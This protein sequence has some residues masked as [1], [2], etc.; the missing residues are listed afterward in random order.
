MVLGCLWQKM[1]ISN[2]SDTKHDASSTQSILGLLETVERA[3]QQQ[4][5]P[6][7][8][9]WLLL[10]SSLMDDLMAAF[11]GNY[12]IITQL[13]R[14]LEGGLAF[15]QL[16]DETIDECDAI[17]NIREEILCGR[18]QAAAAESDS[19]A[20]LDYGIDY[21]ERYFS[22]ITFCAYLHDDLYRGGMRFGAW[23]AEHQEIW[24]LLQSIRGQK[25][26]LK[27]FRPISHLQPCSGEVCANSNQAPSLL[28][29]A[30]LVKGRSG[31][32][33]SSQTILKMDHYW[34][35]SNATDSNQTVIRGA[36]NFRHLPGDYPIYATA[37]PTLG[38]LNMI[39]DEMRVRSGKG[40]ICWI[41]VREEPLVYIKGDP[42]VLRDQHATLRNI[43]SYK[44][45][46]WMRLEQ[47]EMRLKDDIMSEAKVHGHQILLHVE[48]QGHQVQPRWEYIDESAGRLLPQERRFP[49]NS[50]DELTGA[51]TQTNI[52]ESIKSA[53]NVIQ[54]P[55]EIFTDLQEDLPNLIYYR[56]P[57]T[58]G[59]T[60]QPGDIEKVMQVI[61]NNSITNGLAYDRSTSIIFN[62]Q[63]GA[64]RSTFGTVLALQV[65]DWIRGGDD[66]KLSSTTDDRPD[67]EANVSLHYRII[68]GLLRVIPDGQG[69][70]M[71]VDRYI[72]QAGSITNLRRAIE[73]CRL[74]A[75]DDATA[76]GD[77][78]KTWK[79]IAYLKR[80]FMLIV[81][82][83]YLH[84]T[85]PQEHVE[86]IGQTACAV[87]FSTWFTAHQEFQSLLDELERHGHVETLL[88]EPP[89]A[90]PTTSPFSSPLQASSEAVALVQNRPGSVL[91]PL[92]IL[93]YDHFPGC[94]K[95]CLPDR[96]P[97][98]PNYR[99]I[100]VIAQNADTKHQI[101]GVAMPTASAVQTV[102]DRMGSQGRRRVLWICLREEPVI[103]INGKPFV[104]RIVKDPVTNLEM[105]GI[106]SDRVEMMEERL[107]G[108]ILAELSTHQGRILIHDEI[109]DEHSQRHVT[110]VSFQI[111]S[112]L[113]CPAF[114]GTGS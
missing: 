16:V 55:R 4:S 43:R 30:A 39:I 15:K 79:G 37:Q 7:S 107:K 45:I 89:P 84:T 77:A 51:E 86:Y 112:I 40:K 97:G 98:A 13:V 27:L 31:S 34:I 9:Q 108:D 70:K 3:L 100:S 22:L 49:L 48:S 47:M 50:T 85:R 12:L 87:S 28:E 54:T 80:Y 25:E 63:C 8:V 69:C 18:I 82:Q 1:T 102:L 46:T 64:G 53:D 29:T 14:V 75:T 33:L 62:C 73:E 32:V 52:K 110:M 5:Q 72:D 103:F 19:D 105:T 2:A 76:H 17:I 38:A 113:F 71:L 66:H 42:F 41:N 61:L 96:L 99:A 104:L 101:V 91:A 59:E 68:N 78:I 57:I 26:K 81:F 65:I 10:R 88:Y 60:Y 92:T 6:K 35:D 114:L 44:G 83:A 93:K 11:R 95:L 111:R 67:G 94:Q 23:M 56:I 109:F 90:L 58:A 24:T 21:L 20:F 74:S 36:P 106:H